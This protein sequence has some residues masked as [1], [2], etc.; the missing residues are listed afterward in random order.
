MLQEKEESSNKL[1]NKLKKITKVVGA[2]LE[3]VEEKGITNKK[4]MVRKVADYYPKVFE[5]TYGQVRNK[6][7]VE[8]TWLGRFEPYHKQSISSYIFEMM[9]DA[10][11]LT[12]AEEYNLM[13]FEVNVLDA[14]RTICEKIM[15]LVRFSYGE[16][17][18]TDLKAKIRHTHDIY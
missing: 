12:I 15:S 13:S 2:I 17:L 4:G 7:I 16:N 6:I 9:R 10:K 18:I 1:G 14:R 5:G 3:E 11:Q 8:A